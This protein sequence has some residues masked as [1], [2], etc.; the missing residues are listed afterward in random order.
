[1]L[2]SRLMGYLHLEWVVVVS[3]TPSPFSRVELVLVS[4]EREL[5]LPYPRER[6]LS[7]P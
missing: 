7:F 5:S 2:G 3:S 4:V 1:M 6:E